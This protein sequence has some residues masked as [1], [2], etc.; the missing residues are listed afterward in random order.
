MKFRATGII[1]FRGFTSQSMLEQDEIQSSQAIILDQEGRL[2]LP[3]LL[4]VHRD[5]FR[6]ITSLPAPVSLSPFFFN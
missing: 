2:H 6:F 3:F 4:S 5:L 1:H